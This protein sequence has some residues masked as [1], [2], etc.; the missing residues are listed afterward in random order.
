ML[1]RYH[2]FYYALFVLLVSLTRFVHPIFLIALIAYSFFLVKRTSFRYLFIAILLALPLLRNISTPRL[3]HYLSGRV[4][5]INKNNIVVKTKYGKVKVY[6]KSHFHY[7][8]EISFSAKPLAMHDAANDHGFS[9]KNYLAG[10]HIIGKM[11][12]TA[13][14]QKKSHFSLANVFESHFSHDATL[15]SYQRLFILGIKDEEIQ[16]DY[17]AMTSLSIVHMFALSGMHVMI[18]YHVLA[19]LYGLLLSKK[20]AHCIAKITIAFYVFSIPF[21]ISLQRAFLMLVLTDLL[22]KKCNSLDVLGLLIIA[23]LIYNPYVIFSISFVFS[24][25][26]YF[27]VLITNRLKGQSILIYLSTIPIVLSLNFTVNLISFLLADLLIPYVE[28]FYIITVGSMF[29]SILKPVLLVMVYIFSQ[30]LRM[31]SVLSSTLT[32]QKPTLLFM[33]LFYY[34][35]FT[36]LLHLDMHLLIKRQILFLTSLM[37]S[38]HIYSTYKIYSEVGMVNVGQGDCIYLSLPFNK[39]NYLIDTGGNIRYDVATTTLIP[40]LKAKGIDHLDAVYISHSDYDHSGALE[41]LR[42]HFKVKKVITTYQKKKTVGP[43][44]MTF[45]K[46]DHRYGNQNDDCNVQY[47]TLN[48][49]HYLFTGDL[50]EVGEKDLLKR[51]HHLDVDVLKVG[52]HGSKHSSSVSLFE[53]IHPKIA[54]IGVGE[55]NFY[56]HPSDLVIQRLKQRNVYILRTDQNGNFCIRDYGH[57]HYIFKHR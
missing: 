29:F 19:Q 39:G 51:Y 55:N 10:A 48:G 42:S 27:I 18:L 20:I 8:D 11:Y 9:E 14:H 30:I 41:S 16:S 4:V 38:F 23:H 12:M 26:I 53:M 1:I 7:Q 54:F 40:F 36:I 3:P 21:N 33:G 5:N 43:M 6:T 44:T 32:F 56:G 35:Y 25:F 47:M 52:H 28:V 31:T 50:S 15:K 22:K 34:A 49:Y 13:L 57:N 17:Q 24:Y 46:K 2:L 45:L 37:I